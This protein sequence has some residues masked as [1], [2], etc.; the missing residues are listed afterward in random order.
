MNQTL[1][2][3]SV[4]C[5]G[6]GK[7]ILPW[8]ILK[9]PDPEI[10]FIEFFNTE[11]EKRISES[12]KLA[13][14]YAGQN[15]EALD[16]VDLNLQMELVIRLFGRYVQNKTTT[17]GDLTSSTISIVEFSKVFGTTTSEEHRPSLSAKRPKTSVPVPTSMQHA[18]NTNVMIQCEECSMWR[19]VYSPVKLNSKQRENLLKLEQYAYSLW[20]RAHG[21]GSAAIGISKHIC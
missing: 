6:R 17:C 3:C 8:S 1:V 4:F 11:I 7:T 21:H 19:L 14:A 13:S 2:N 5:L 9:I 18:K 10:S 12:L 20:L 16:V 15:K